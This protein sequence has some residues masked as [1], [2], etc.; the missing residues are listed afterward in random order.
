MKLST[1]HIYN[2]RNIEQASID[3]S[4]GVNFFYGDNGAGK[5]SVLEALYHLST[6]NSFRTRLFKK[7]I[8][9]N[10]ASLSIRGEFDTASSI[11]IQKQSDK[12][13]LVKINNEAVKSSS[14]LA[15][16]LPLQII[17]ENIFNIIDSSAS[18]RRGF[19][20]WGLFHVEPSYNKILLNYKKALSQRNALLKKN[21]FNPSMLLSWETIMI[22]Y[23][24]ALHEFRVSYLKKLIPE[25]VS[26]LREFNPTLNIKINYHHGWGQ[27]I[28]KLDPSILKNELISSR[29]RDIELGYTTKGAQRADLRFYNESH[30]AKES[31]SRGQQ[32]IVLIA[33]KLAQGNLLSKKC[34]YLIDDLAAELDNTT[35]DKVCQYL[36][37]MKNQVVITAL[38]PFNPAFKSIMDKGF[39]VDSG[40]ILLK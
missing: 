8:Q 4:S 3:L 13:I 25:F 20:D 39:F 26:V 21:Q 29:Q 15:R 18:V 19:L 6:G 34:L 7:V 17:Y 28:A 5:T 16:Y 12:S 30:F 24:L 33:L 27:S 14:E 23:G 32:K 31:L 22:E 2:F 9:Y 1:L 36:K 35:L 40:K 10:K 11:A 38:D 37:A